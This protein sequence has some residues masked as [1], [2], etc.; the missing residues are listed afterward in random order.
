MST[1][2]G[3]VREPAHTHTA[4]TGVSCMCSWARCTHTWANVSAAQLLLSAGKGKYSIYWS[5]RHMHSCP[6]H[7]TCVWDPLCTHRHS[8]H[9]ATCARAPNGSWAELTCICSEAVGREPLLMGSLQTL[10]SCRSNSLLS[11]TPCDTA[12]S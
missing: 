10:L 2:T 5:Y 11:T 6:D 12:R 8:A 7:C 4:D 1:W 9:W 3:Q